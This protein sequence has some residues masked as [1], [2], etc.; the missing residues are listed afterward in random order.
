MSQVLWGSGESENRFDWSHLRMFNPLVLAVVWK[1]L[2]E[3]TRQRNRS[4]SRVKYRLVASFWQV[5]QTNRLPLETCCCKC[6]IAVLWN[7][8]STKAFFFYLW[9]LLCKQN[10]IKCEESDC[11]RMNVWNSRGAIVGAVW[12]C[13]D[14][15]ATPTFLRWQRCY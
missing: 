2:P 5:Q 10:Y 3:S 13:S 14:D 9:D 1:T 15:S 7:H 4:L 11:V 6:L 8:D 12:W